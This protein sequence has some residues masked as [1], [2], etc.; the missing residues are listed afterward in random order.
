GIPGAL[1]HRPRCTAQHVAARP[2]GA[3]GPAHPPFS[4]E[5][6][7]CEGSSPFLSSSPLSSAPGA[8]Q[9]AGEVIPP[10]RS[11]SATSP[12]CSVTT[13]VWAATTNSLSNW[14][15]NRSTRTVAYWVAPSNS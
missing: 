13:L 2:L 14:R 9:E 7:P 6:H 15:W 5:H 12:H 4:Q 11:S 10:C 1:V 8:A 3:P